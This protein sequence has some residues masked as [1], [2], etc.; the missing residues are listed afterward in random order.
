M[1][2]SLTPNDYDGTTVGTYTYDTRQLRQTGQS[3]NYDSFSLAT[4][5]TYNALGQK[6]STTYPDGAQYSYTY[7]SNNQLSTV[8][9]PTGTGGNSASITINSYLWTVP[10][11]ITLPGGTVRTQQYD[12]LL[13]LKTLAVKDPGQSSVMN[14]QYNYDLT[15][16]ITTKTTEAG[17]T[18]YSY[19][20]LDR[21]TAAAYTNTAQTNEAYSYD[22]VANRLTDSK[23]TAAVWSYD[24]NNQ[25]T[26]VLS[27]AGTGSTGSPQ[28]ISYTYD[29][30]GNTINTTDSANAAN[31]HNYVYDTD[32]RLIEVRD[33]G[34]TLIAA[35]SYDPFGRRLSKDAG[36]SKTYYLYNEA[37][38][39][40]EADATGQV[41]RSYGYAPGST[42]RP[43]SGQAYTTNPLFMKVGANYYYYQ[44]DHLGTPQKLITQS[45]AAVWSATYDAFGKA[46][47]N[48]SSTVTNNLRL[49]GQ[50]YDAETG[51]H[52]NW[53]RYYDPTTGR[54]VTSDPIGLLG[55]INMYAYLDGNP[56]NSIDPFG[57]FDITDPADWPQVP[58]G[59]VDFSA[60][61]GDMLS[62]GI[63]NQIRTLMGT[64]GS[65]NKC[66]GAYMGGE[67]FGFVNGLAL[68][69]AQGMKFTAKSLS[70]V[71][72]QNFSHSFLP[73]RTLKKLEA[74]GIPGAKW[75]NKIGNRLNG[76]HIPTTGARGDLHDLMDSTAAA[77]GMKEAE[78]AAFKP[79][80][81]GRQ[82]INRIPYV[83]GSA[84]YGG[85]SAVMNSN[86]GCQ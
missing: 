62:F 21:L 69:W 31:T 56:L 22:P 29:A 3:V 65:V 32:N 44:N 34:N 16:N 14:Y 63:T 8:N 30:N 53:M 28:A 13:R 73:N 85:S 47:V 59:V 12:G 27:G 36:A 77:A 79:W 35:Y 18:N 15:D 37:G 25:L 58:Q 2:D 54:Y 42:L 74:M 68:G 86:C 20:T 17:T 52:Y 72:Y 26:Q 5:T 66:S 43:S 71:N 60:G 41:T 49:P 19:D 11:Q 51:L 9:L 38:L 33:G 24:E 67:A 75:F 78:R 4:G 45:G 55:G 50:Y 76:D 83:P 64:N 70:P 40:A 57:L 81:A 61:W 39:I 6:S 84:I 46:T 48:P 23:T 7:D 10:S 1:R 80:S 82:M